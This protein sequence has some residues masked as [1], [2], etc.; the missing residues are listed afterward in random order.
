MQNRSFLA[1][2]IVVVLACAGSGLSFINPGKEKPAIKWLSFEQLNDSMKVNPKK[3]FIEV[4]APWC[5]PCKMMDKKTFPD[6]YV[7]KAMSESYY[8]I[9]L[10]GERKD[11][12][13]FNGKEYGPVEV[14][15]G[16][17]VNSLAL[18]IGKEAGT[19]AYPTLVILDEKYELKYRYPSFLYA[20]MMEEVLLQFK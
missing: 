8:A 13:F 9:K 7:V 14:K 19:L 2:F 12:I 1:L 11:T 18:E 5:G 15:P 10:D 4:Y 3:I 20:E 6:K 16:V 17:F